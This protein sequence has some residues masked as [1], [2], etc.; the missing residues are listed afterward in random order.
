[1]RLNP[2]LLSSEDP[3]KLPATTLGIA[4]YDPLRDEGL[5]YGKLL[6]ENGVPTNVNVFKG[7]PHGFRR[8]GERLSVCKQW[9]QTMEDGIRCALTNPSASGEFIIREH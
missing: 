6:A 1:M 9:D 2:G 8:F 4:G 7:V 3:K 5:L